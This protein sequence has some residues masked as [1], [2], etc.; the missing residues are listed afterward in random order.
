MNKDKK[1][2]RKAIFIHIDVFREFKEAANKD[3][4]KYSDFLKIL[5]QLY[6][7]V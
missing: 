7:G 6:K 4:R 1:I 5:L 3:G 2:K